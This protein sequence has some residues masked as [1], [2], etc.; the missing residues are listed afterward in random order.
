MSL[1][2]KK[3]NRVLKG[4]FAR[5]HPNTEQEL[6]YLLTM[7]HGLQLPDEFVRNKRHCISSFEKNNKTNQNHQHL[8]NWEVSLKKSPFYLLTYNVLF[9]TQQVQHMA[10]Q[11]KSAGNIGTQHITLLPKTPYFCFHLVLSKQRSAQLKP[12]HTI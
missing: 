12:W 4:L 8:L 2:S 6:C 7:E 3:I 11:S 5:P 10:G 1:Y 9:F